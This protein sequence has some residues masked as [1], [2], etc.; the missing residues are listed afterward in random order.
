MTCVKCIPDHKGGVWMMCS[1]CGE[2]LL[3]QLQRAA[4][5]TG[6][7]ENLDNPLIDGGTK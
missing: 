2:A 7:R 5:E 6:E 4:D 3:D 1:E